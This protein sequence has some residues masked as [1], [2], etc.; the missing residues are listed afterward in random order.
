MAKKR[1]NLPKWERTILLILLVAIL[2][3]VV[4]YLFV[5]GQN[6]AIVRTGNPFNRDYVNTTLVGCGVDLPSYKYSLQLPGDWTITKRSV[7]AQD[8]YYDAQN[9]EK[10]ITIGCTTLGIGGDVCDNKYHTKFNINNQLVE[11]CYSQQGGVWVLGT[12]NLTRDKSTNAAITIWA[13]GLDR[14]TLDAIFSS[15]TIQANN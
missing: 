13:R 2:V 15:F 5:S 6:G 10:Q 11:A 4:F 7:N 1:F 3:Y 9:G 12:L 14:Q 8:I